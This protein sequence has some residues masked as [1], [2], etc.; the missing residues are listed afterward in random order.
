[1]VPELAPQEKQLRIAHDWGKSIVEVV[2]NAAGHLS[3]GAK[4]LLL[5]ELGLGLN[6]LLFRRL[7]AGEQP[8]SFHLSLDLWRH[9]PSNGCGAHDRSGSVANRRESQRHS[10]ATAALSDARGV[11]TLNALTATQSL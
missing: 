8:F 3:Q 10:Q 9:V 6:Q 1:L 5:H 11:I 7:L 2:S 4:P